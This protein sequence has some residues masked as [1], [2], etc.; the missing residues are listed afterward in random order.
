[1]TYR[2]ALVCVAAACGRLDFDA[3]HDCRAMWIDGTIAFGPPVAITSLNTTGLERDPFLSQDE[4]TIYFSRGDSAGTTADI[5]TA[6]R[7]QPTDDF[8]A[9]TTFDLVDTALAESKMSISLDGLTLAVCRGPGGGMVGD[10]VLLASRATTADPWPSPTSMYAT[11][12]DS[13]YAVFDA[14][15]G[16]D[17]DTMYLAPS[18]SAQAQQLAIATRASAADDFALGTLPG[19]MPDTAD[20]RDADPWAD[21]SGRLLVFSRD[22]TTGNDID[23]VYMVADASGTFGPATTVPGI[24]STGSDGD[25]WLAPGACRIYFSSTRDGDYNLYVASVP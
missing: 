20:V 22:P 1:M 23:I 24:N 12:I 13:G 5:Y 4:R 6:T 9:A 2:L 21:P 3:V 17:G 19:Y 16:N 11:E 25:P 15:L 14:E 10:Q 8:G 7:A 18:S